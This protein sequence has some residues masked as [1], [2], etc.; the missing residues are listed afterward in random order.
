MLYH[1]SHQEKPVHIVYWFFFFCL[2]DGRGS[3]RAAAHSAASKATVRLCLARG[4]QRVGMS[5][6][7]A[8]NRKSSWLFCFSD[9]GCTLLHIS[10]TLYKKAM[11]SLH[12]LHSVYF[13]AQKR[14]FYAKSTRVSSRRSSASICR[15]ASRIIL[16][17]IFVATGV[18]FFGGSCGFA[19]AKATRRFCAETSAMLEQGLGKALPDKLGGICDKGHHGLRRASRWFCKVYYGKAMIVGLIGFGAWIRDRDDNSC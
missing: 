5:T 16:P 7:E 12:R 1:Y 19:P 11:N 8:V 17:V 2:R 14:I 4:F 15:M 10:C 13:A 18:L 3:N 9:R 6:V